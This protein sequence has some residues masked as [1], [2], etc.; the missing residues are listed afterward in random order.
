MMMNVSLAD[1]AN[2]EFDANS[3]DIN[4][5]LHHMNE[6]L[7]KICQ[8]QTAPEVLF[9]RGNYKTLLFL[10]KILSIIYVTLSDLDIS[11]S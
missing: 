10:R 7:T 1:I 8:K 6:F 4:D 5:T 9:Q 3:T 2:I 11:L